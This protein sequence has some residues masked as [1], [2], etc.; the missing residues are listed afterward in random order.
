MQDLSPFIRRRTKCAKNA[1]A[2]LGRLSLPN[3]GL[4]SYHALDPQASS[5]PLWR[6]S[7]VPQDVVD[8]FLLRSHPTPTGR[9]VEIDGADFLVLHPRCSQLAIIGPPSTGISAFAHK[10][11]NCVRPGTVPAVAM[12]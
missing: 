6:L 10:H 3:G 8:S 11:S 4:I 7:Q 1:R 12:V 2:V 9:H 5:P